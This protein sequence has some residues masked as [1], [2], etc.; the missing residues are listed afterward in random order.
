M[1]RHTSVTLRNSCLND[2][3]MPIVFYEDLTLMTLLLDLDA[4]Q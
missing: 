3:L 2:S 4:G 1:I